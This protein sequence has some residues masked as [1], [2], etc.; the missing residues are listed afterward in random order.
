MTRPLPYSPPRAASMLCGAALLIV[1]TMHAPASADGI[2]VLDA[3]AHSLFGLPGFQPPP[4]PGMTQLYEFTGSPDGQTPQ[5]GVTFD[6]SGHLFGTTSMGGAS[7][8]GA[9]Y[10]MSKSG[11]TWSERVVLAFS[12]PDGMS[13]EGVPTV[14]KD[15]NIYAT[16]IVGGATNNGTIVKLS[17]T[18]GGYSET[19]VYSFQG[20]EGASPVAGLL[21]HGKGFYMTTTGGGANG[22]G[23]IVF[24]TPSLGVTDVYDFHG[25]PVDGSQP[26]SNLIADPSGALYGTT[27]AG[28]TYGLGTVFR[29]V[30]AKH[31][32]GTLKTLYSFEGGSDGM[33]PLGSSVIRDA[34]GNLYG[35]TDFGGGYGGSGSNS[36]GV[37]YRL[38]PVDGGY[39]ESVLH[40]FMGGPDG[41]NPVGGLTFKGR[42][43]YGT[44]Y[45]GG[46]GY[47]GTIFRMFTDGEDYSVAYN[48]AAYGNANGVFSRS[49]LASHGTGLYG[50]TGSNVG[51]QAWGT[52]F[53]F[54]P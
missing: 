41:F 42:F 32:Q 6:K 20:P 7:N 45:N 17:P 25:A 10:E 38:T 26:E 24:V 46:T 49:Q 18:S 31:G 8:Q 40:R 14:D 44:T 34:S 33:T 21:E 30:P 37:V 15:G 48:F 50:T 16:T 2:R 19:A 13:P 5:N 29:F 53:D 27:V 35:V 39:R 52:V 1:A 11:N 12:G 22:F 43:M 36:D 28:G 54:I 23:S 3:R 47:G 4:G 51:S 9:V